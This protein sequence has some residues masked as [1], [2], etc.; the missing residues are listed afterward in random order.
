MEIENKQIFRSDSRLRWHSFRL[1]IGSSIALFILL[2][3]L[4]FYS[5]SKS[6]KLSLPKQIGESTFKKITE[7][8]TISKA[9]HDE[10]NKDISKIRAQ[11]HADFYLRQ[12]LPLFKSHNTHLKPLL[13]IKA[14]FFVNW[15]IQSYLSLRDHIGKM[16]V[17]LPEWF[18]VSD[19]SDEIAIDFNDVSLKALAI[20]R[21]NN[22][23]IV[24]MVSNYF[25][26]KWNGK[27]VA[28]IIHDPVRKKKFIASIIYNLKKYKFNGVNIDFEELNETTDEYIISFQKDL[29]NTL[30]KNGFMVTQD[31]SPFNEDYNYKELIKYNDFIFLMAYDQHNE[32]SYPGAVAAQ[33]WIEN[34]LDQALKVI[35][36]EKVV[37]CI[38]AYGYDWVKG[39]EGANITY[40]EAVAIASESDT[41]PHFNNHTYN[42]NYTYWDEED[43]EH[44]V[45]FTDAASAYNAM[46]TGEDFGT[47]GCALWRLGSEDERIWNFY[48]KNL[49][50]DSIKNKPPVTLQLKEIAASVNVDYIGAGEILNVVT[51]PSKGVIHFEYD[52]IDQLI[53][54][55]KYIELPSGY[56]IRKAGEKPKMIVLSFDDGPDADYTP[57][58]ISILKKYNVP[59]S[60]FVT[61]INI[62]SDVPGLKQIYNEGYEIGNHTYTHVNLELVSKE[63]TLI[64][65]RTTRR[66]IEAITDHSTILFRAPYN[67]DAEPT[68][69]SELQPIAIGKTDNY[70]SIGSSIDPRDWEKGISADTI[71]ARA[72]AQ[73]GLGNIILLHDAGGNREQTIKALPAII[74][75]YKN[76][77]YTFTTIAGLLGKP[78]D[79]LMPPITSGNDKK[80]SILNIVLI[81]LIYFGQKFL[82]ALFFFA[83]IVT[84]FR[85]IVIAMLATKK[86]MN[87]KKSVGINGINKLVSIII[88]AYNE[89]INIVKTVAQLLESTYKNFE[90]IVVD[91]GSTDETFKKVSENF[92]KHSIVKLFTKPNGGKASAINYGIKIC[93]GEL[94][95]CIDAD[96]LI[97]IDAIEKMLPFF[98]DPQLA[99]LSGNVKVGNTINLLT[100]WQSIEYTTSQ[101]FDRLAFDLLNAIM[102]IPG[103]IGMFRKTHVEEV[104]SFKL[105]TLAEDCDLT[106]RLLSAG[107]KVKTCNNAYAFTEAPETVGAFMKQRY[108]WCYGILQSFWKHKNLL[109]SFKHKNIGWIL[110]PNI[111]L[112]Q[113]FLP[114]FNPLVDLMLIFSLIFGK[115]S[116]TLAL[117]LLYM[118]IEMLVAVLAYAY[119]GE[120]IRLKILLLM[121][122]QRIV[123][124][125][126]L[127][128]VLIKSLLNAIKGE[129]VNWGILKRSGNVKG[130][131]GKESKA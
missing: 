57:R 131:I 74:E 47:A 70:I 116:V 127:F 85:A 78:K 88:P 38:S 97:A 128:V 65:L 124:R 72:I 79:E 108:R 12:N 58:I 28:R 115:T 89:E 32:S 25:N 61:G 5:I 35:P 91:D 3:A 117:Y 118:V 114:L 104:G 106:M 11:N 107:Y 33:N 43:K 7:R 31:V 122:P 48:D 45:Y 93:N 21:K 34:G 129:L 39:F 18:F 86:K 96:T 80:L 120:K 16:N 68:K 23:H 121:I 17:V 100:S 99:G 51:S 111:I 55:E 14:G 94:L 81:T 123:Y 42:L 95:F 50:I 77:G 76:N 130:I 44:E 103:A 24:P 13:P 126:L 2:T 56:V 82:F 36:A 8:D 40:Q 105:D 10:F 15:D 20:M 98:E 64:E 125:Q 113:I 73:K 41:I 54:E 52:S 119:E 109:F 87:L 112:F 30:H 75:Y 22:V 67:T 26:Q 53:S 27:N 62:Q 59:A 9:T 6:E 37:L 1:I 84:A 71:I 102:V 63:R 19:S 29:Y 4:G 83:L 69:F 92:Y 66:M 46:R 60:F 101:N 49:G 110:L 90:I